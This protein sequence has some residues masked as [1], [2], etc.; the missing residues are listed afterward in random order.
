M[1]S[2]RQGFLVHD[3]DGRVIHTMESE[4]DRAVA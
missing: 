1:L 2:L 3:P 4:A